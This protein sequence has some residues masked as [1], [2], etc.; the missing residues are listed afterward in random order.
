IV[1]EEGADP[2]G[3][4]ILA[5]RYPA[6]FV[7]LP[8][9]IGVSICRPD[10]EFPLAPKSKYLIVDVDRVALLPKGAKRVRIFPLMG[11]RFDEFAPP[12]AVVLA[13]NEAI[14]PAQPAVKD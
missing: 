3:N 4:T 2:W 10:D 14:A 11:G 8:P 7:G 12:S 6:S 1:F 13:I 5:D 9:G